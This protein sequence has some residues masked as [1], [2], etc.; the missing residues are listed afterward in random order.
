MKINMSGLF[1]SYGSISLQRMGVI[2]LLLT[3]SLSCGW[4]SVTDLHRRDTDISM[5][6][7]LMKISEIAQGL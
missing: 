5:S 7:R 1:S 4:R 2:S 6:Y 3:V